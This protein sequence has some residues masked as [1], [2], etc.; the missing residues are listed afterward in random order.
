[1]IIRVQ[2]RA[3]LVNFDYV[4]TMRIRQLDGKYRIEAIL[5]ETDG[6]FGT[7]LAAYKEMPQ[8]ICEMQRFYQ[9]Y[10]DGE[11]MFMFRSDYEIEKKNDGSREEL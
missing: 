11:K 2:Y 3:D 9:A 5:V 4:K 6:I 10:E 7:C 1:M 8:A